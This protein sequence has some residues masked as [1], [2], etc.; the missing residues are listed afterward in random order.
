MVFSQVEL[1]EYCDIRSS[2]RI[3]AKEYVKQGIPFYRSKEIIQKAKNE[4][5]TNDLFISESRFNEI[6]DKYGSPQ[7]GDIL[8][9]SVGTLGIPYLVKE[10]EIFYFKDG[11]LTWFTNFSS[12]LNNEFLYY[13]F[14]SKVGKAEIDRITIGSTQKALTIVS[15]NTLKIQLPSLSVQ[16][17]I[18]NILKNIDEKIKCNIN[19][20]QLIEQIS[21]TLFKHWFI[22]FQFPNEQGQ[23]YKSSGGEM[24]ESELGEIPKEWKVITI[25]DVCDANKGSLS[26]KDNWP[27]I[28][29]LDTSN[30]TKNS[31]ENIQFIDAIKDKIP[32]R[33]KRKLQ[34]NDIVY[35]TVRP[36][37]QHYGIIKEPIENMIVS[38]GFTVLRSK[39]MYSNDLIYLWL[40]QK[41]VINNL[42]SLAEQ[43]ASAY[44]SIKADDI[45]SMKILLPSERELDMLTKIIKTHNNV[46]WHNHQEI[47]KLSEL[48]DTLLPKLLSGEVE[49]SDEL[50]V[51]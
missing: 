1:G 47:K 48:R 30:I 34:A 41:E 27:Y 13:W 37:Q 46:I 45:L 32:S 5:V 44:P 8:L 15:L 10:N 19:Q 24:T 49:I 25:K 28:N 20:L 12:D 43:S 18:V 36:N 7:K 11:N 42:Q 51:Y 21:Q 39:G 3:Y 17:E 29:Y 33:A 16:N 26:K 23:P 4:T 14:Q 50:V 22:D 40:T 31:I 38:T 6:N 35:S 9:T 2:K